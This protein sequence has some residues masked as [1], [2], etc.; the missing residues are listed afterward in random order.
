MPR[1]TL[2]QGQSQRTCIVVPARRVAWISGD[3][4]RALEQTLRRNVAA[5]ADVEI[6]R[7]PRGLVVST[8]T[9]PGKALEELERA[10][11]IVEDEVE[12]AFPAL[13]MDFGPVWTGV[14][15]VVFGHHI[16]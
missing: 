7:L 3:I 4:G 10:V 1:T 14:L 13:V 11:R 5:L 16:V 12:R 8:S 15:H 6:T 2:I 9:P